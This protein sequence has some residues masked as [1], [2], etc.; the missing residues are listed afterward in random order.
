MLLN[1]SS[2]PGGVFVSSHPLLSHKL[3]VLRDR[4]TPP[5]VFRELIKEVSLFLAYEALADLSLEN[6]QMVGF[7][8]EDEGRF[9]MT[10]VAT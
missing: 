10:P 9:P 3:S 4:T 2:G 7:R 5:K 6:T 1:N 8:L